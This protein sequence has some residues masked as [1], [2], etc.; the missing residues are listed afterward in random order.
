MQNLTPS[1][2]E[3]HIATK[4]VFLIWRR[5]MVSATTIFAM[6]KWGLVTFLICYIDMIYFPRCDILQIHN[7]VKSQD[8][9]LLDCVLSS[10]FILLML[11]AREEGKCSWK[12]GV[13]IFVAYEWL[14]GWLD[15]ILKLGLNAF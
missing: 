6:L 14:Y 9:K 2:V 13:W 5:S 1:L 3:M 4:I 12:W 8:H 10:S 15:G 11:N 7:M